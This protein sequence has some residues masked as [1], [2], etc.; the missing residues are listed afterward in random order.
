MCKSC[1]I[2]IE[3]DLLKIKKKR[4]RFTI[5]EIFFFSAFICHLDI[6]DFHKN[7]RHFFITGTF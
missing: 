2:P 4:E 1:V 3:I 5:D 7:H 6:L